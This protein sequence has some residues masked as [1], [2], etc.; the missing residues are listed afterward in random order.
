[1]FSPKEVINRTIEDIKNA[2]TRLFEGIDGCKKRIEL[3][4]QRALK[5]EQDSQ[6][7]EEHINRASEAIKAISGDGVLESNFAQK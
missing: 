6:E 7:H 3:N 1:M 2:K 4:T 5:I